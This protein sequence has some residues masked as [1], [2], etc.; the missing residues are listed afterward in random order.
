MQ[1][2]AVVVAVVIVFI[3][4]PGES[5][6][7]R[8]GFRSSA[9]TPK[10]STSHASPP[11]R[12]SEIESSLETGSLR[13]IARSAARNSSDGTSNQ[14][15]LTE[16]NATVE[17]MSAEQIQRRVAKQAEEERLSKQADEERKATLE[18]QKAERDRL[19]MLAAAEQ[20]KQER[21]R[22]AEAAREERARKQLERERQCNIQPVMTDAEI[23]ICKEVWR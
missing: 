4:F 18:R 5:E 21:A 3:A 1:F 14:A 10:P 6:A 12:H 19:A 22:K 23:A 9:S 8:F 17:S 16:D 11:A 13:A 20:E 2:K 7:K 15:G